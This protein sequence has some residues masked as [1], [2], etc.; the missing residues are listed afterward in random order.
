MRAHRSFLIVIALTIAIA[1]TYAA[2]LAGLVRQWVS[3][4]NYSHGFFVVPLA[5]Y[6]AWERR[7]SLAGATIRPRIAGLFIVVASLFV[8]LAGVLGVEL[9]LTRV[10]LIGLI[11]GTVVFLLGWAHLRILA[12]PIAFL[13]LMIPL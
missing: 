9:F 5:L 10:S 2:V 7:Q 1:T 3:D 13:L 12:F 6:F 11:A 8:Y 4:D